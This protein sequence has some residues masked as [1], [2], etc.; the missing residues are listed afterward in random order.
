[1]SQ[2]AL[3]SD[4]DAS[5][6]IQAPVKEIY[7]DADFNC[8]G[9]IVPADVIDLARSVAEHGLLQP[10]IIRPRRKNTP[11]PY[12]FCVISG[13]RRLAAYQLNEAEFIPAIL[14]F[15][16]EDEFKA[17][18]FNSIENLKRKDLTIGQEAKAVQPYLDAG[19]TMQEIAKELDVSQGWVFIRKAYTV[20]PPEIQQ[21]ADAGLI[22]QEQLRTLYA[23]KDKKEK[24][25]ETA[26]AMKEANQ[27]KDKGILKTIV[28]KKRQRAHSKVI[29]T[30]P[31]IQNMIDHMLKYTEDG[32]VATVALAWASG[33]VSNLD[34]YR[35]FKKYCDEHA[36][37]YTI[38]EDLLAE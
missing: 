19:W 35:E 11:E 2:A 26:K 36:I 10:I 4:A 37:N 28:S 38:P 22:K 17:R 30:R 18:T 27:R 15:D 5:Q 23:L 24:L 8:R 3:K 16:L 20:Y 32:F 13:H 7:A 33:N 34:L 21:A 25:F 12:K 1:M 31:E 29:R 6:L 14:R 9:K